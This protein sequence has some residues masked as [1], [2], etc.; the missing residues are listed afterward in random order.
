MDAEVITRGLKECAS[1]IKCLG[2]FSIDLNGESV[3]N[4]ATMLQNS[5]T[6]IQLAIHHVP[7]K[8][9][10]REPDYQSTRKVAMKGSFTTIPSATMIE[11]F[12]ALSTLCK[13]DSGGLGFINLAN[14]RINS[15]EAARSFD[16]FLC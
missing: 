12:S 11:F 13:R 6:L 14:F 3:K 15:K 1:Q 2:L 8:V 9:S 16:Q 10:I 4:L 5:E 7:A